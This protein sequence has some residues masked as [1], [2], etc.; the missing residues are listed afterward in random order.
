MSDA[1]NLLSLVV[2][3]SIVF[4]FLFLRSINGKRRKEKEA[5][6]FLLTLKSQVLGDTAIVSAA[7]DDL[8]RQIDELRLAKLPVVGGF[9]D[10]FWVNL[11]L[12][13]WQ[14]NWLSRGGLLLAPCLF[15]GFTLGKD[16]DSPVGLSLCLAVL[17]FGLLVFLIYRSAMTKHLTE[18]RQNLPQAIDSIVRIAR[19]GVPVTN[20]F[21]LVSDSLPGPL[22]KEFSLIDSWLQLGVPMRQAMQ[23][24]AKRVPLN[25]YRFFVVILIINQETGGRLSDTLE[26]LSTTLRERQEL[27]LKIRA[28]TSEVRASAMI[29]ATLAPLSLAYMYFNSPKDFQFLLNDPTGNSVL[30]YAFGSVALGLGITH[31]MIRR[32]IR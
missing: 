6:A 29:V 9:I 17:F 24:S 26:R 13:G 25:E 21:N 3:L 31:F 27:A 10:R 14:K 32:V 16:S 15:L 4:F 1:V 28:K 5:V 19:A 12:L 23:D 30:M 22:A 11:S 8:S 20:A 2:F 18:F 7:S